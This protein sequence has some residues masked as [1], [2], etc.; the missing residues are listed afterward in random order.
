MLSIM[1]WALGIDLLGG[2]TGALRM[3]AWMYDRSGG[4]EQFVA[5]HVEEQATSDEESLRDSVAVSVDESILRVVAGARLPNPVHD[6]WTV[7]GQAAPDGLAQ[8]LGELESDALM[9]GDRTH[10]AGSR[11][12]RSTQRVLRQL[13]AATMIVPADLQHEAI[14]SGP[15]VIATDLSGVSVAAGRFARALADS[16]ARPLLVVAVDRV[17]SQ[18]DLLTEWWVD[19]VPRWTEAEVAQ[20]IRRS[21]IEPAEPLLCRGPI[22]ETLARVAR[23]RGAPLLVCGARRLAESQRR[24]ET[25]TAQGLAA[26]ERPLLVVPENA[27]DRS[28]RP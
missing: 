11:L 13:P 5:V 18:L 17:G 10:A 7:I 9:L 22:V 26:G 12:G 23:E 20:W 27:R 24:F 8:A 3:A 2:S 1:R 15:I 14:G 4:R 6:A 28:P 19:V 16:L 25:S 21:E